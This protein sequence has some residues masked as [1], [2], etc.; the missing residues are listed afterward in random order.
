M[1]ILT[2]AIW[3]PIKTFQEYYSISQALAYEL[4]HK[5]G[6]PAKKVG[7]KTWRVD[8]SKTDEYMDKYFNN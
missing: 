2:R 7:P 3:K 4:I 6:F 1:P 8:M 5:D